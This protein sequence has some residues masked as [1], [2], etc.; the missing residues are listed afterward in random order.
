MDINQ[1]TS[2]LSAKGFRRNAYPRNLDTDNGEIIKV[3]DFEHKRGY[4]MFSLYVDENGEVLYAEYTKVTYNQET[5]K[6][7]QQVSRIQSGKELNHYLG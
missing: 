4:D 1:I 2:K 7:S 3:Y 5:R 6:F